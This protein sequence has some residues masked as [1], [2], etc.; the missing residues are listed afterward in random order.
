[1]AD[2]EQTPAGGGVGAPP[3]VAEM[4]QLGKRMAAA[5]ATLNV[6]VVLFLILMIWKPGV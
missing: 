3:Q 4:E 1:M 5:G 2:M 6:F